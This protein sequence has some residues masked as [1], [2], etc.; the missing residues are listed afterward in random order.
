MAVPCLLFRFKRGI[1][2]HFADIRPGGKGLVAGSGQDD[3]AHCGIIASILEDRFQ[4]PHGGLVER[5]EHR[6][7][8]QS[9]VG[10]SVLLLVQN[11]RKLQCTHCRIHG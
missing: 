1:V 6:R 8:V 4:L 10:D 11:V 9:D 2:G 7:A 5:I 3:A